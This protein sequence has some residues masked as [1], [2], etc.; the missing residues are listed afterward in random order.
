MKRIRIAL[1]F[2]AFAVAAVASAQAAELPTRN[3]PPP[4]PAVKSCTVNGKPGVLAGD[5]GVCIRVSGYVSGQIEGGNLKN[6]QTL[7]YH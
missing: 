7:I 1:H 2:S 3:A 6:S 5:S 4:A